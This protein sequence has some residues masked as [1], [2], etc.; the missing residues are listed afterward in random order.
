VLP[1]AELVG[2]SLSRVASV[3]LPLLAARMRAALAERLRSRPEREALRR[4]GL[5][6]VEPVPQI[7]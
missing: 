7:P 6:Q 4:L 2:L 3:A 5:A 1:L